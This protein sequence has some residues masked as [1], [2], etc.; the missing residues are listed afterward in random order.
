[1]RFRRRVVVRNQRHAILNAPRSS[2]SQRSFDVPVTLSEIGQ[3]R[4]N[5]HARADCCR[6]IRI[7]I[8]SNVRTE[9]DRLQLISLRG[10]AA[11]RN[12]KINFGEQRTKTR[13]RFVN[14][15]FDRVGRSND[16]TRKNL[17][18][19]TFEI[20]RQRSAKRDDRRERRTKPSL[21]CS[22]CQQSLC[23]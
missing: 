23:R 18:E 14:L 3:R 8:S 5:G 22:S 10:D 9:F 2:N 12:G 20:A 7:E 15:Q 19:L 11:F 13:R 6:L 1:M 16:V 21:T 17:I 4:W